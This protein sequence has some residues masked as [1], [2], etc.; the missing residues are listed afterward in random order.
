MITPLHRRKLDRFAKKYGTMNE[1]IERAL[2]SLEEMETE[3]KSDVSDDE[4]RD[5]RRKSELFDTLS[6]FSGFVLVRSTTID[7]LFDIITEGTSLNE[8]LK[9]HRNWAAQDL[10]IQKAMTRLARNYSNDFSSLIEI[11]QQISDT[12]RSFYVLKSIE[13]E[14]RIIIHPNCFQ[15]FP[16]IIG[17]LLQGILSYF[18]FAISYKIMNDQILMEWHESKQIKTLNQEINLSET[19]IASRFGMFK[20]VYSQLELF[21]AEESK[22]ENEI[23]RE[24]MTTAATLEIP[25]WNKG[26]F[27]TGNR[28]FTY[29]PQNLL[30]DLFDNMAIHNSQKLSNIA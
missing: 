12:F 7:S 1:V 19:N 22:S 23:F 15:K 4:L 11:I 3:T 10:E 14:K 13:S 20:D 30:V 9:D 26:V 17:A 25:R 16:E 29:V 5:L 2:D 28:R 8:F 6:S 21:A 18:G 24:V 27:T